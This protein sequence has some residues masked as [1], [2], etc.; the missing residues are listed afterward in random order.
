MPVDFLSPAQEARYAAFPEPLT[1]DL[2]ARHAFLDATDRA[3]LASLRGDH[4]RLG[5]AV[6][7]ATVRCL[8]TF[9][10]T[11]TDVPTALVS[12]LA[13]QLAISPTDHLQRYQGSRMRWLHTLDIRQ[14]YGYVDYTHPQRG[15][16]FARWL[17]TRAWLGSERPSLLFER[18]VSWL[19]AEKGSPYYSGKIVR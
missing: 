16:R 10:D 7:L 5:Y 19:R 9:R 18:A 12:T 14:R 6:Q 11:P 15:W 3:V 4:T 13:Q 2:L 17:F 1:A 8:G